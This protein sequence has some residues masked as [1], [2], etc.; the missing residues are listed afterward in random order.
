MFQLYC[1]EG[2]VL[3][4]LLL[5]RRPPLS[6]YRSRRHH[7]HALLGPQDSQSFQTQSPPPPRIWRQCNV[8]IRRASP[9]FHLSFQR[10]RPG[11]TLFR[12][13]IHGPAGAD[14]G[15]PGAVRRSIDGGAWGAA[16]EPGRNKLWRVC[17]VQH[18]GAIP[19]ET[20][21]AGALLR[22]GLLGG[23]GYGEWFI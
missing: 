11:P 1:V 22:W 4:L 7:R 13:V 10:L 12:L 8:A 15:V 21:E 2:L 14:R 17:W 18:G 9:P 3:P 20:G 16:N 23:E 6:V 5:L 19:G